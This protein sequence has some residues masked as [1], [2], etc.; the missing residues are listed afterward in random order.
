MRHAGSRE[1][2]RKVRAGDKLIRFP[3]TRSDKA[4]FLYSF[5]YSFF[6]YFNVLCSESNEKRNDRKEFRFSRHSLVP[7]AP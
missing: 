6:Y 1:G 2:E 5:F 7:L 3:S 4:A